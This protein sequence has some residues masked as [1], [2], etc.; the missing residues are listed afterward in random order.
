MSSTTTQQTPQ[1]TT[2]TTVTIRTSSLPGFCDC[3]RRQAA[4]TFRWFI[5]D[6][7]FT[8]RTTP[9]GVSSSLG[10]AVH[11]GVAHALT[12]RLHGENISIGDAGEAALEKFEAEMSGLDDDGNESE[13]GIPEYDKTTAG[14]DIAVRQ[15]RALV[16]Q[17]MTEVFPALGAIIAVEQ[18][19]RA[20]LPRVKNQQ[21][22]MEF[23]GHVDI[24]EGNRIR[25]IKTG[26]NGT[27]YQAQLGGYALLMQANRYEG[28]TG[29]IETVVI[30]HLPRKNPDKPHPGCTVYEYQV[31][32]CKQEARAVIVTVQEAFT[33]FMV[34]RDEHSFPANPSSIL[35]SDKWCPAWGTDFCKTCGNK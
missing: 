1:Q 26:R 6:A 32:P 24:V 25:D 9:R 8:L 35:C 29:P 33:R 34:T 11:A 16:F 5:T 7:G 28:D 20:S 22:D 17:Y 21:F 15:I 27:G 2:S 19:F 23:T 13:Y 31:E 18:S 10:T 30:D 14:K 12:G 3:M 4:R